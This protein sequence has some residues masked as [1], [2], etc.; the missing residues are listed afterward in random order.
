MVREPTSRIFRAR[1]P[2]AAGLLA[3]LLLALALPVPRPP[4]AVVLLVLPPLLLLLVGLPAAA[5]TLL[6]AG[7]LAVLLL[8][9]PVS[10]AAAIVLL[11]VLPLVAPALRRPRRNRQR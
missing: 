10:L 5:A 1:W 2:L 6:A 8:P 9:S 7:M 3:V 11:W 4:G